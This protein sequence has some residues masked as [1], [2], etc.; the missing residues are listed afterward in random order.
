MIV[1]G[2]SSSGKTVFTKQVL[3]KSYIQFE[4]YIG[5]IPNSKTDT[6]IARES[7]LCR[8]CHPI[9]LI[10]LAQIHGVWRYDDAVRQ[11]QDDCTIFHSETTP[12]KSKCH[13]NSSK[14]ILPGK[15]NEK[16]TP[17]YR[18]RGVISQFVNLDI[19]Q[20]SWNR[21]TPNHSWTL[22]WTPP[23]DRTRISWWIW[24]LTRQMH[25]VTEVILYSWIDRRWSWLGQR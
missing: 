23:R 8:A 10:K 21:N 11:H 18:V 5:S 7:A 16:R 12:P 17:Q 13:I 22:T 20:N 15:G 3:N 1:S 14:L 24:N 4:K 19:W 2:P 9:K 25:C 6:K